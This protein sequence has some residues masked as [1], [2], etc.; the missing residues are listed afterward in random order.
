MPKIYQLLIEKINNKNALIESWF[1]EKFSKNKPLFY[2]SVDLRYSG[3]KIA[4]IDTNCFPAGFNNLSQNSKIIA[5]TAVRD[6]L[7]KNF[8]DAKKILI[9]PENHTRNFRYLENVLALAQIISEVDQVAQ[10]DI[11]SLIP[12]IENNLE[13]NL[14]NGKKII[15]QKLLKNGDKIFTKN[16]KSG[17][18]FI[19]DLVISNNDFTDG[20]PDFLKDI[21]QP[22][23]PSAALGWH[24]RTKSI[25]FGIYNNLAKELANLIDIDP[26]LIST[27]HY[28]CNE[29]NFKEGKGAQYL[30]NQVDKLILEIKEKYQE[31]K[32]DAEPYCYIKA[33]S[34]TYG[35][36]M[37]TAKS[38]MDI[39]EINK[40]ERNKMN[41]IKGNVQNTHVIIQEGILTIDRVKNIIAEPMIYLVNGQ[42][43][44]NLFRVNESRNNM[45]SLN[46][47]GMSFYDMDDLNDDELFL[48][49]PKNEVVKIYSL[50]AR[51]AALA[52]SSESY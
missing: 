13:I 31:Y 36:G 38:S 7:K 19:P 24:Q 27:M 50:I 11:G 51:L 37:M 43:V 26:W 3:F 41:I 18:I 52:A 33:D 47:A 2:N 22:I 5:Q 35:L 20:I 14:E 4:P 32:I 40:K 28:T 46:A 21:D 42:V 44:G 1:Q 23:V 6:F 29:I 10:V 8:L 34:G 48:G 39:A 16:I 30:E 17:D 49:L 45:I 12:E 25:H 15:L 9:I